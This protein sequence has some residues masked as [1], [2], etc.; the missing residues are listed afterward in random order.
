[1]APENEAQQMANALVEQM[2][3]ATKEPSFMKEAP[4]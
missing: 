2:R 1:M 4:F 3:E